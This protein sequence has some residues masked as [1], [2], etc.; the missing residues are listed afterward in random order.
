MLSSVIVTDALIRGKSFQNQ[1]HVYFSVQSYSR[2]Q[3]KL[4]TS[5]LPRNSVEVANPRPEVQIL[6][7]RF[8][9]SA[10]KKDVLRNFVN[11]TEKHLYRSLFLIEMQAKRLKHRCFPAEFTRFLKTYERLLPKSVV[12]PGV[13][14]LISTIWLKLIHGFFIIIYSSLANFP[15]ITNTI[16]TAIISSSRL[17]VL[18]QKGVLTNFAKFTR[19]ILR[20][21]LVFK[22][23]ADLQSL[24]LSKEIP[25]H[26]FS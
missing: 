22:E 10:Y 2:M 4:G 18:C 8:K 25:A 7:Q 11:F 19:K 16:D 14:F 15:F 1:T 13:Y 26:V 5:L 23:A 17:V 6:G 3:I 24:T 12:S 9:F 21:G 20:Q